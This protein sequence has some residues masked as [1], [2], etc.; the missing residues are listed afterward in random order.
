MGEITP[1]ITQQDPIPII[2][3]MRANKAAF[4]IGFLIFNFAK[5]SLFIIYPL[6]KGGIEIQSFIPLVASPS[7][8]A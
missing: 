5:S 4:I 8:S 2:K 3:A 7:K 6:K 1:R